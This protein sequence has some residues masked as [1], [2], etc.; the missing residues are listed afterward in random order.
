M[1]QRIMV[2]PGFL[3]NA[4]NSDMEVFIPMHDGAPLYL[5]PERIL[6]DALLD[7]ILVVPVADA[8][9]H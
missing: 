1:I 4:I 6:D 3:D 8:Q 2:S 7:N 5:I 9:H